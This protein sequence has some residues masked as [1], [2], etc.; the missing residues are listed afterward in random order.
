VSKIK[1]NANKLKP[2][3]EKC[4]HFKI[5]TLTN[6]RTLGWKSNQ[7]DSAI[8]VLGHFQVGEFCRS[9]LKDMFF[10]LGLGL[11]FNAFWVLLKTIKIN[12]LASIK[13][14]YLMYGTFY[15]LW[16]V[17]C[18]SLNGVKITFKFL[19]WSKCKST[20]IIHEYS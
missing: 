7:G 2:T 1:M 14:F 20:A 17:F 9:N 5:A 3:L 10:C 11:E 8:N 16:N 19:I 4:K 13:L 12:I 6:R 15:I 18:F